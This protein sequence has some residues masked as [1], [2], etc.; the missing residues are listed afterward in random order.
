MRLTSADS[1]S[2]DRLDDGTAAVG[3]QFDGISVVRS[4]VSETI[5]LNVGRENGA[6]LRRFRTS[7]QK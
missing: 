1:E 3:V 6:Q 7:H 4:F 2:G 5:E